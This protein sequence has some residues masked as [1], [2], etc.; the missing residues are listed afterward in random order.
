[1]GDMFLATLFVLTY[2]LLF[3]SDRQLTLVSLIFCISSAFCVARLTEALFKDVAG[4]DYVAP[5]WLRALDG[6]RL[7]IA[8]CARPLCLHSG[9]SEDYRMACG[10]LIDLVHVNASHPNDDD[11]F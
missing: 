1:M 5:E 2:R 7:F 6:P 9:L 3:H 11:A 4:I 8:S 10:R